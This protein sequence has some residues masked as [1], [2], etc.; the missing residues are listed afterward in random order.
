MSDIFVCPTCTYP[1]YKPDSC[2]NPAC[3]DNPDLSQ[4]HKD[5]LREMAA[6]FV[7]DRAA[8]EAKRAF[9]ASLKR[10]GFTPSL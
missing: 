3:L 7:R 10:A 2:D 6:K 4:A 9:R 1:S 5:S 8:S